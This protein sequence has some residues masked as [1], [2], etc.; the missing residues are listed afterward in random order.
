MRIVYNFFN[1][2]K[3]LYL[4]PNNVKAISIKLESN[5][6]RNPYSIRQSLENSQELLSR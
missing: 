4:L 6:M 5:L 1:L 3:S 2:I